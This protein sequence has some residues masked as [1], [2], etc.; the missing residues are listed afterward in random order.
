MCSR[1]YIRSP[2]SGLS[3]ESSSR[4]RLS[5]SMF[6]L[7]KILVCGWNLKKSKLWGRIFR[8]LK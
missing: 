6:Y 4:I 2:T 7:Y 1:F 8:N 3:R 5:L